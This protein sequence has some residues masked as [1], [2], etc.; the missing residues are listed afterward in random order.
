MNVLVLLAIILFALMIWIGGKKGARSFLSLFLNFGVILVSVFFMM[1]PN[2]DPIIITLIACTVISCINLFYIN[3]V[4]SKTV[5]AFISTLITVTILLFFIYIV[6]KKAM[7]QGFGEEEMDEISVI[8]SLYPGL[9]FVKISAAVII[10]STIGAVTDIAISI[11]SPMQEI[12]NQHP[13]IKKKEL[14]TSG[15]SIGKDIL[16]SNTNTLF[17]AFIGGYMALL[18][19]YK[20][21]SYSFGDIVNSKIFSA[22]MITIFCAGIGIALVIPI[23]SLINAHYL[24][25]IRDKK[26]DSKI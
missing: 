6:T 10:M 8:F 25:K 26:S 20:D 14:F 22:E 13:S 17:F 24:I 12:F 1:D 11:T 15:L 3:E 21:L 9:D 23:A 19:W 18:I 5:T 16:G 7:I 2:A 4:N